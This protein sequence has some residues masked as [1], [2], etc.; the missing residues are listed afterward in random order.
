MSLMGPSLMAQTVT[1]E[2]KVFA[3]AKLL[4]IEKMDIPL[5]LKS[6]EGQLRE[7]V[8]DVIIHSK[9]HMPVFSQVKPAVT[10]NN[11]KSFHGLN[12]KILTLADKDFYSLQMFYYNWT[13]NKSDKKLKKKISKYN[14]LNELR[15]A[16]YEILLGKQ[17]VL[18]NKDKIEK[19]NFERIIVIRKI[20]ESQKKLTPKK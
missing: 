18:D 9:N 3:E 15:F 8:V 20:I 7:N 2:S 14:V 5:D 17:W 11:H 1:S 12:I 16:T 4:Q 10:T 13:T 6:I 19:R